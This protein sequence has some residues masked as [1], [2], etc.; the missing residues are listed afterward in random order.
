M[1][2]IIPG[3]ATVHERSVWEPV[4]Y[5]MA[6]S[7]T[8]QPPAIDLDGITHP[9]IHYPGVNEVPDGD[10]GEFDYQIGPWLANVQRWYYESKRGGGYTRRSDGRWFPGYPIGYSFGVDWLGGVWELRGFDYRPAATYRHNSYTCAV[11][12]IV[13]AGEPATDLAWRSVRAI[14]REFHRRGGNRLDFVVRPWGHRQ[15]RE[16]TGVGTATACPSDAIIDQIDQGLGDRTY[17]EEPTMHTVN[18][19]AYDSRPEHQSGVAPALAAANADVPLGPMA[20]GEMRKI[21]VGYTNRAQV[22][23]TMVGQNPGHL[24]MNNEPERPKTS[25]VNADVAGGVNSG[26]WTMNVPDGAVYIWASHAGHHVVVDVVER[27]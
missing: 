5:Q 12:I 17:W 25:I 4:D 15:F 10:L 9:A 13:D 16:R 26:C 27:A 14:E 3:V 22:N 11:F 18:E 1:P 19:R 6:S 24:L 2:L 21:V 20:A 8:R 7:F 23:V